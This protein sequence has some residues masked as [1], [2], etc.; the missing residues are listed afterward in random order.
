M[1]KNIGS[2]AY[3]SLCNVLTDAHLNGRKFDR[4]L[5]GN[6]KFKAAYNV[7]ANVLCDQLEKELKRETGS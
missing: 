6:A 5:K 2:G 7:V 3:Q 4:L 1:L